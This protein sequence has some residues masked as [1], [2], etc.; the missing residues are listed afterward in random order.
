MESE[1]ER[2]FFFIIL[3]FKYIT[4]Y[5]TIHNSENTRLPKKSK[6]K[7]KHKCGT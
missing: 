1:R 6:K 4:S 5:V 2:D 3:L 7:K